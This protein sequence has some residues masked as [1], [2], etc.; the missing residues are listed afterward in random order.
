MIRLVI[1]SLML[2]SAKAPSSDEVARSLAHDLLT[3][4]ATQFDTRDAA[5]MA[6]NYAEDAELTLVSKDRDTGSYKPSDTR[7]RTA[8]EQFYRDLYKDRASGSTSRNTVEYAHFIA[9]DVLVIHGSF[10]PDVAKGGSFPF[11]QVRA[12]QGDRWLIVNLQ[13]FLIADQDK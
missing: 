7:G 1:L 13:L 4:G 10:T 8:I 9:S 2:L 12:K 6:A 3:K 5:A 11:V